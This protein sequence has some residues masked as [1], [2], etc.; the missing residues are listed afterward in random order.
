M[1]K[2]SGTFIEED[3]CEEFYSNEAALSTSNID[4]ILTFFR[5][6][7]QK[8]SDKLLIKYLCRIFMSPR[9]AKAFAN[10]LNRAVENYETKY[11]PISENPVKDIPTKDLENLE[12]ENH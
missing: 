11:G 12:L 9:H 6:R 1:D 2:K 10:A 7:P 5:A 4:F 3:T 8:E